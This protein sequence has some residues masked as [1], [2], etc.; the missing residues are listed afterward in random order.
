MKLL[1]VDDEQIALEALRNIIDWETCG[2]DRI[3]MT[4]NIIH[5]KEI[6]QQE[7]IDILLCDIEMPLGSGIELLEWIRY[8]AINIKPILLTCH[9]EFKYAKRALQLG[10]IDYLLKPVEEDE[11]GRVII[12]TI[13]KI[14][15]EQELKISSGRRKEIFWKEVLEEHIEDEEIFIKKAQCFY[16]TEGSK[17][18]YAAVLVGM[19]YI[20]EEIELWHRELFHFALKNI[21]SEIFLGNSELP[22]IKLENDTYLIIISDQEKKTENDIV[23][24]SQCFLDYCIRTYNCSLVCYCKGFDEGWKLLTIIENLIKYNDRNLIFNKV[25]FIDG[26]EKER[27]Y[28]RR[29]QKEK[30]WEMLFVE[31]EYDSLYKEIEKELYRMSEATNTDEILLAQFTRKTWELFSKACQASGIQ[32]GDFMTAGDEIRYQRQAASVDY[33][34]DFYRNLFQ[35]LKK[36]EEIHQLENVVD[37]IKEYIYQNIDREISREQLAELMNLNPDYLTRLFRRE[38]GQSLKDYI[39]KEK[40]GIARELLAKTDMSVSEISMRV[41][42][43]NFSHF[44]TTFKKYSGIPPLVYRSEMQKEQECRNQYEG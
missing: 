35:N 33:A 41:G 10:C 12:N 24:C 42:F 9:S 31:K 32:L 2:I 43:F 38:T 26:H 8:K 18:R 17:A 7:N 15:E 20:P 25:I 28:I 37:R 3:F 5:A 23:K 39:L 36:T 30:L 27:E 16:I 13:R 19:K 44:T 4:Y 11:L 40:M 29:Q 34:L 21:A 22:F 1:I 14:N 6:I